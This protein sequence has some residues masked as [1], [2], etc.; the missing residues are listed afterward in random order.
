MGDRKQCHRISKA[1]AQDALL[2][3]AFDYEIIDEI[4]QA[5]MGRRGKSGEKDRLGIG[6]AVLQCHGD[7]RGPRCGF[8]D[9]IGI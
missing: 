5:D 2:R 9:G 8:R 7:R 6:I 3:A 1:Q 4:E